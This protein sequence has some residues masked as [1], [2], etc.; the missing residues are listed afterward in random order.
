MYI[1]D[2]IFTIPLAVGGGGIYNKNLKIGGIMNQREGDM[3]I[4]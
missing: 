1:Y 2:M 4:S 3:G